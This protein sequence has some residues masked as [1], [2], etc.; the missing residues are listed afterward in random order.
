MLDTKGPEIRTGK[1]G[2]D[3]SS[4]QL[5]AGASFTWHHDEATRNAGDTTQMY[6]TYGALS[7]TVRKG[8]KILCSDALLSFTVVSTD[9]ATKRVLCTVDNSG[10]LGNTKNM[11]L[12]NAKVDLPALTEKDRADIAFGVQKNVD[13]IAA[14]FIRKASDVLEIRDVPGVRE[15]NIFICSKIE[16]QEG[17]DNFDEIL[18][19]TDAVMVARGDLGSEIPIEEVAKAQ[20]MMIR[21]W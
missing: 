21:K 12:P 3:Q 5:V 9:A 19:V 10:T 14:S 17:L 13:I 4:V 15:K 11:N 2:N 18:A 16:N 8:S 20:K 6:C 7:T 1:L